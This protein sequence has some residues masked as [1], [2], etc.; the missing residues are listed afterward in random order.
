VGDVV[1]I[2]IPVGTL[3]YEILEISRD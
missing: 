2:K 1:Q 3:E